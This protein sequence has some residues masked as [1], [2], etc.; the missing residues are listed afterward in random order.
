MH[1]HIVDSIVFTCNPPEEP[2]T[3][4]LAVFWD[5]EL[6]AT[7]DMLGGRPCSPENQQLFAVADDIHM[8]KQVIFGDFP[9]QKGS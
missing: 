4:I 2:W 7:F 1:V 9:D 5:A 8:S 6:A 3:N